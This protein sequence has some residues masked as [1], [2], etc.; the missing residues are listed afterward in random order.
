ME[1]WGAGAKAAFNAFVWCSGKFAA[2]TA[3]Y[4][5]AAGIGGTI[6]L[7]FIGSRVPAL[8]DHLTESSVAASNT[9]VALDVV[10]PKVIIETKVVHVVNAETQTFI[11]DVRLDMR[12]VDMPIDDEIRSISDGIADVD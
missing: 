2:F 10:T 7:M 5:T 3:N 12:Y 4:P 1:I 11:K 6:A 9:S 8:L